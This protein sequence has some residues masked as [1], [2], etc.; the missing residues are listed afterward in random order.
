[1]HTQSLQF[2]PDRVLLTVDE[3]TRADQAAVRAGIPALDLME[4][5]GAA[6]ARLALGRSGRRPTAV[7]CGPGNN[8]GD[9]FVV[10]RLLAQAGWPVTVA[11]LGPADGLRGDAAL[12]AA[13]WSGPVREMDE[14]ALDGAALVVDALFGAGL[15]KPL[16]AD[17]ES[18]LR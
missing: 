16:A 4:A 12:A 15:S 14:R 8:G 6:V 7:L 18:L 1:M 5:A 10:A 3:M 13:D 11:S 17:L 9:G 2:P